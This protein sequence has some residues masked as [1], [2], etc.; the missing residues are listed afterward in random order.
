MSSVSACGLADRRTRVEAHLV[1]T[2]QASSWHTCRLRYYCTSLEAVGGPHRRAE[3]ITFSVVLF[4]SCLTCVTIGSDYAVWG[5]GKNGTGHPL[6]D[7]QRQ[8]FT[9]KHGAMMRHYKQLQLQYN[10][11]RT[12]MV[13]FP[14]PIFLVASDVRMIAHSVCAA[15]DSQQTEAA[16]GLGSA[17]CWHC[18]LGS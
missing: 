17:Q 14:L 3:N 9:N 16:T 13:S 10:V 1:S 2:W 5:T 7:E 18:L 4:S 6:T 11:L 15:E 12:G 8:N